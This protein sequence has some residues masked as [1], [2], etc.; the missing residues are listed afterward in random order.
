MGTEQSVNLF[1]DIIVAKYEDYK[2][3][4]YLEYIGFDNS[5]NIVDKDIVLNFFY[6]GNKNIA[7]EEFKSFYRKLIV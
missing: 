7:I 6:N 1:K 3:N 4:S 5:L 2:W